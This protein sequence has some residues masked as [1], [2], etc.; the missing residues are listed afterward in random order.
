MTIYFGDSTNIATATGLGAKLINIVQHVKTAR[1]TMNV[2][3]DTTVMSQ[4][5]TPQSS[6][7]KIL[8]CYHISYR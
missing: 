2:S 3:S 1:Q 4:A 8:V 6:S 5:I 7:H